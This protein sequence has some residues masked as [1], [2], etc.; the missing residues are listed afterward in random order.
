MYQTENISGS[1]TSFTIPIDLEQGQKYRW[2]MRAFKNGLWSAFSSA[3]YFHITTDTTYYRL[4]VNV[5]PSNTGEIRVN[6]GSWQSSFTGN[7]SKNSSVSIEARAKSGY[8]FDRWSG[9]VPS[10][11][12]KKNPITVNMDKN[13]TI[14]AIFKTSTTPARFIAPFPGGYRYSGSNNF[15][16]KHVGDIWENE[17]CYHAGVDIIGAIIDTENTNSVVNAKYN[18]KICIC[19]YEYK[20]KYKNSVFVFEWKRTKNK[21]GTVETKVTSQ[22]VIAV[23]PGKVIGI[24]GLSDA[25][26]RK[27]PPY[28]LPIWN[29]QTNEITDSEVPWGKERQKQGDNHGYGIT[30]MLEH[31]IGGKKIYTLYAHLW[32]V[33]KRIVEKFKEKLKSNETEATVNQGEPIGLVGNS[34]RDYLVKSDD[35]GTKA[36]GP[37]LHFEVRT[38]IEYDEKNKQPQLRIKKYDG[39]YYNGRDGFGYVAKDPKIKEN[40]AEY[41]LE[42]PEHWIG[43]PFSSRLYYSDNEHEEP[44]DTFEDAK[45][46]ESEAITNL[47]ISPADVDFFKFDGRSGEQVSIWIEAERISSKLDAVLTLYDSEGNELAYSN[48]DKVRDTIDPAIWHFKLP[49]TGIYYIKVESFD[50]SGGEDYFYTLHLRKEADQDEHDDELVKAISPEL[51]FSG[52]G[53]LFASLPIAVDKQWHEILGIEKSAMKLAM[54]DP[55]ANKY[56][57][58]ADLDAEARKPRPGVAV[59]MKL[60][61]SVQTIVQGIPPKDTQPFVIDLKPG[62]NAIGVPWEV[63]WANLRVRKGDEEVSLAE[64]SDRGWVMDMLWMWDGEQYQMV[65]GSITRIGLQEILEQFKGYWLLA[66]TDCQLVIPPKDDATR[67]VSISHKQ[68]AQAGWTL[69]LTVT[70]GDKKQGVLLGVLNEAIRRGRSEQGLQ[71]PLPPQPP[72]ATGV[73]IFFVSSD[74]KLLAADMRVGQK[75]QQVWDVVVRWGKGHR[76]KGIVQEEVTLTW[77]G[78][79]YAPKGVS[80]TLVDLATGTRRYMR[81]QTAYRFVPSDGETERRFKVIAEL[82]NERPL[83]IVGLRAM[84]MRGQGVLITFS[85]TKPA[86]IQVEVLTLTGRRVAVLSEQEIRGA[87]VQRLVWRGLSSDGMEVSTGVY[88]VRVRATDDEGRVVQAVTMVRK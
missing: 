81:T 26:S 1:A 86:Q 11:S 85:L 2:N 68:I 60:E 28:N 59:W 4:Q 5:S 88:L 15:G 29:S 56:R 83:R 54:W 41:F 77:D 47:T 9:D 24:W 78:I 39:K 80:L 50:G 66:L 38:D 45:Q 55:V 3:P 20:Y 75:Q 43:P 23:A 18:G 17:T 27:A 33:E 12:E 32:A 57:Y 19:K 25:D 63:N 10:G 72:E 37:H 65:W 87:G 46:I 42:D 16:K 6:N 76:V 22:K 67:G 82:G 84:P 7:F 8:E 14:T 52:Q 64:A 21:D 53:L 44:N 13:R 51:P 49:T 73:E 69:N 61:Q 70:D 62:W 31:D 48:D 30:V 36:F 71:A 40:S 79:G 74:G 34:W 58:Y 35:I